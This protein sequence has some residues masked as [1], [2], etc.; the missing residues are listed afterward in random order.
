MKRSRLSRGLQLQYWNTAAALAL[1][2]ALTAAALQMDLPQEALLA[3]GILLDLAGAALYLASLAM[4][5]REN[6]GYRLLLWLWLAGCLL[7]GIGR[8]SLPIWAGWAVEVLQ[9]GGWMLRD[10][11]LIHTT[12]RF[13]HRAG[14]ARTA[15]LGCWAMGW[16]LASGLWTAAVSLLP[17]LA[18]GM[19][20][21]SMEHLSSVS[22]A[23]LFVSGALGI[24]YLVCASRALRFW[25]AAAEP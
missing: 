13:L 18:P 3:P 22:L 20:W 19:W 11:L 5:W 7:G 24:L 1:Q 2:S 10:C 16:R 17:R 8:L 21:G 4:L 15:R 9:G 23:A 14:A 12:S 6:R 25:N